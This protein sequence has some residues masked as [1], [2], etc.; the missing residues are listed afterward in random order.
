M[1]WL[2]SEI[3]AA[4]RR[5]TLIGVRLS[6]TADTYSQSDNDGCPARHLNYNF[7]GF[8]VYDTGFVAFHPE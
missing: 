4:V 6:L 7:S 8:H 2:V 3:I 5:Y 1:L